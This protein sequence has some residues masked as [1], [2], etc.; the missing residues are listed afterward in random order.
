MIPRHPNHRS[1]G[2]PRTWADAQAVAAGLCRPRDTADLVRPV[3]ESAR[4]LVAALVFAAS[5]TSRPTDEAVHAWLSTPE[6]LEDTARPIL[7]DVSD[8]DGPHRHD[9]RAALAVLRRGDHDP[10]ACSTLIEHA[11]GQLRPTAGQDRD[12]VLELLASERSVVV[13]SRATGDDRTSGWWVL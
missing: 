9:A 1:D 12:V 7:E 13:L 10:R 2:R 6:A 4:Q 11:R 5:F 8:A 3:E